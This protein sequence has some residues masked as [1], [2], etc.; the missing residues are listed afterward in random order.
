MSLLDDRPSDVLPGHGL[1]D[2][3][4]GTVGQP[5]LR[6]PAMS[7]ALS[8][9][10]APGC[11]V[12][13]GDQ[14]RIDPLSRTVATD[15]L[16]SQAR[17][18]T[19]SAPAV[20]VLPADQVVADSRS[21]LVGGDDLGA[22]H[23]SCDDQKGTVGPEPSR[24]PVNLLPSPKDSALG[25]EDSCGPTKLPVPT[26]GDTSG[27]TGSATDQDLADLQRERVGGTFSEEPSC[28]PTTHDA[29]GSSD[30]SADHDHHDHHGR[31]DGSSSGEPPTSDPLTQMMRGGSPQSRDG[32]LELRIW[33]EM[34]NDAQQARIAAVNRAERGGVSPDVYA[35]YTD[36]LAQAEHVCALAMRRCYRRVVPTAVREWQTDNRGVGEHFA[37]RLLGHLGHPRIATPHWWEG[38]GTD[39]TLMAG[40]AYERTVSQLWQFCG[41]GDPTRR[42]RKGMTADELA[43]VGNPVLK[44]LVHLNAEACMKQPAGNRYRDVYDTRRAITADRAHSAP[45]VR[46]G[47]SGK[48]AAEGTPWS[49]GHQ[50]ADAL[51]IVGKELLRDLWKAA[52]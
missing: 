52:S 47:P 11:D 3:Q 6:I 32:W 5:S 18:D 17:C 7:F 22:D 31:S 44:M 9:A 1:D 19:H 2:S 30:S 14:G 21:G 51:R 12:L 34:F 29:R 10:N 36:A 37:A 48:P 33:S 43:A 27:R 35:A 28:G 46:C 20:D 26:T 15:V 42:I 45:C 23:S 50:H 8:N 40:E 39:R 4:V 49:K 16:D 41:H 24:S 38:S 13:G 25:C